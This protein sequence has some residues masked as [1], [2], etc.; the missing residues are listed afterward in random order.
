MNQKGHILQK[1][2]SIA[3][4]DPPPLFP[5]RYGHEIYFV[6]ANVRNVNK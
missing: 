4:N 2:G 3:P 6:C 5:S 1:E